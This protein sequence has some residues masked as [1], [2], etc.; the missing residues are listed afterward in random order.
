MKTGTDAQPPAPFAR[1]IGVAAAGLVISLFV[2]G[3]TYLLRALDFAPL[4][5]L[6]VAE[7]RFYDAPHAP[8]IRLLNNAHRVV[9]IDIDDVAAEKWSTPPDGTRRPPRPAPIPANVDFRMIAAC[10][11]RESPR[12]MCKQITVPG[13][14]KAPRA[15][16][17]AS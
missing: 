1:S 2:L 7:D 5:E 9:F 17:D 4:R 10:Q 15:L 13:R 3:F 14:S 11:A 6:I 12:N 16:E 8:E